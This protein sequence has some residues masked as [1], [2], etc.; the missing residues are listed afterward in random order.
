MDYENSAYKYMYGETLIMMSLRTFWRKQQKGT[1]LP[2]LVAFKNGN[3]I[4][5]QEAVK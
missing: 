2:F 3:K 1:N 5:I 4:S